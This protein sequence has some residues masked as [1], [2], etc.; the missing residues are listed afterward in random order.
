MQPGLKRV[1]RYNP[2]ML[3]RGTLKRVVLTC[4]AV[5]LGLVWFVSA[6]FWAQAPIRAGKTVY[7]V[8]FSVG[9]VWLVR[10]STTH[11]PMNHPL[12]ST[13]EVSFIADVGESGW[14]LLPSFQ[15][16]PGGTPVYSNTLVFHWGLSIPLYPFVLLSGVPAGFMWRRWLRSRRDARRGRC[17]TCGYD[18]SGTSGVCPECGTSR[19]V[20]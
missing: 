7:F 18:L 14:R 20:S 16:D 3:S 10:Y 15:R 5:V 12:R 9:S 8:D 2:N 17:D 6:F 19:R 4:L 11:L 1:L 13:A